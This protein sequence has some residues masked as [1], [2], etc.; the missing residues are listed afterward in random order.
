[1]GD[2]NEKTECQTQ[3][4][5][6]RRGLLRLSGRV[7]IGLAVLMLD[8]V[9][10]GGVYQAIAGVFILVAAMADE[11]YRVVARRT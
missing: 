6:K 4:S 2:A 11:V 9:L 1:M 10:A 5:Q 7:L 8:L 3:Q